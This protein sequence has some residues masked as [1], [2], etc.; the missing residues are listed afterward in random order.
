MLE[1]VFAQM[2][3]RFLKENQEVREAM[4][5][6]M[7]EIDRN[8]F[9]KAFKRLWLPIYS[10]SLIIGAIVMKEVVQWAISLI[11]HK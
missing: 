8:F 9:Y 3:C 4:V 6:R 7:Q 5:N 11:P 10:V 2:F 1:G